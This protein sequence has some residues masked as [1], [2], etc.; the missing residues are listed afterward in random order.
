MAARHDLKRGGIPPLR[1]PDPSPARVLSQSVQGEFEYGYG[2]RSQRLHPG[3]LSRWSCSCGRYTQGVAFLWS[4]SLR[5]FVPMIPKIRRNCQETGRDAIFSRYTL[6]DPEVPSPRGSFSEGARIRRFLPRR[7]YGG[8]QYYGHPLDHC[9]SQLPQIRPPT[10]GHHP[11]A[12]IGQWYPGDPCKGRSDLRRDHGT[13][14]FCLRMLGARK[15]RELSESDG[16]FAQKAQ[17]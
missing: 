1:R 17:F 10:D 13:L 12:V 14:V 9:D 11:N 7:A 6:R 5:R 4:L 2:V 8:R 16:Y 3:C 15:I